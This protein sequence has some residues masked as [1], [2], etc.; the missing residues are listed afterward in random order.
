MLQALGYRFF[1]AS[2]VEIPSPIKGGQLGQVA[3]IA[4]G[5]FLAQNSTTGQSVP[6]VSTFS[7]LCTDLSG[8]EFKVICDVTNP[9][10]GPEGATAVYGPQKGADTEALKILEAGLANYAAVAEKCLGVP[11]SCKEFP[12]AGAAGGVGYA[13]LAFLGAELI[14]GWRFF[15]HITSLE[16]CV[17]VSD[18]PMWLKVM[19]LR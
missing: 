9:L 19:L 18:L 4:P 16:E 3:S 7:G 6:E 1:D 17:V 10:L 12:G 2:G 15:A 13:G 5:G 11:Q 8:I 14:P